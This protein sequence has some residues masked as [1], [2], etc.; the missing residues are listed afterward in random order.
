[1]KIAKAK[2]LELA[3]E[4]KV[5]DLWALYIEIAKENTSASYYKCSRKE[6]IYYMVKKQPPDSI[7]LS[8]YKP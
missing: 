7:E 1:M 2:Q 5:I 8:N 6:L 3:K 4:K